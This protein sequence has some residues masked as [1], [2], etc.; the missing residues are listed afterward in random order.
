MKTFQK[1][2]SLFGI[3]I[4]VFCTGC[5]QSE[6]QSTETFAPTQSA[7]PRSTLG[8]PSPTPVASSDNNGT[9]STNERIELYIS[10]ISDSNFKDFISKNLWD[11]KI[12]EEVTSELV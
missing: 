5:S 11:V 12:V 6:D 8:N 2:L 9:D 3:L 10:Q 7:S 4:I 1:I